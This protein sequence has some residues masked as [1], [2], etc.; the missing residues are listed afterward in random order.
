MRVVDILVSRGFA[1]FLLA[2]SL[3]LLVFMARRTGLYSPLFVL[4]PAF[5]FASLFFCTLRR[6]RAR[7][8][9][10]VKFIGSLVFHGGLMAGVAVIFFAPLVRFSA[11]VEALEGMSVSA[12]DGDYV[13]VLERPL[14]GPAAPFI[15][16]KLERFVIR[17]KDDVYPVDYTAY[18][19]I[20]FLEGG[21]FRDVEV[22]IR[23]NGPFRR[24]GY[25]FL[26]ENGGYAGR[27][28]LSDRSGAVLFDRYVK[29]ARETA[30]EDSFEA[31]E[32][33]LVFYT[34]FFPD[35]YVK[36]GGVG[37]RS[38]YPRNPA[39]GIK[40]ARRDDPFRDIFKGVLRVGE[41]AGFDGLTLRLADIRA[42]AVIYVVRDPT[43][44]WIFVSWTAI[45]AGLAMRYGPLLLERRDG[46]GPA[47]S[48]G[49][50]GEAT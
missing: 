15:S 18:S 14:V 17:Y 5:V 50:G 35:L 8:R 6:Y 37:T 31:P 11:Y 38:P 16:F 28:V 44:Y 9:R 26:L 29:L 3:V 13:T 48:A 30:R 49:N 41:S 45:V 36:D 40:A 2:A 20:A 23:I 32:A 7:R 34:R 39:F 22:P 24:G 47:P 19:R 25:T 46:A 10:S 1:V 12:D 33:G 43:Y 21:E 42:F 4:L 27:F